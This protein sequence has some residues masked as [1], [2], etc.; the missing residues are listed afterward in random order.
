MVSEYSR[1]TETVKKMINSEVIHSYSQNC[2]VW[3]LLSYQIQSTIKRSNFFLC[4]LNCSATSLR[5]HM[6]SRWAGI[7][8]MNRDMGG[9]SSGVMIARVFPKTMPLCIFEQLLSNS[10]VVAHWTNYK[11]PCDTAPSVTC[12]YSL[13]IFKYSQHALRSQDSHVT[14]ISQRPI[15]ST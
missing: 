10:S 13:Q 6:R 4:S 1:P 9:N 7:D 8:E 2:C 3:S 14:E 15:L 11:S 5:S 12:L